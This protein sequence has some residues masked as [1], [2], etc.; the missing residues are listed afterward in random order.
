MYVEE[1]MG[2]NTRP[3]KTVTLPGKIQYTVIKGLRCC[4]ELETQVSGTRMRHQNSPSQIHSTDFG[5]GL[6]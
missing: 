3:A 4:R 1:S 5:K 2:G 6:I